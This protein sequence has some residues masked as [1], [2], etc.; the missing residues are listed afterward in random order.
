MQKNRGKNRMGMTRDLFKKIRDIKG[1]FYAK[2]GKIKDR[3]GEDL[4]EA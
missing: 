3:E 4:K 2:V 1:T